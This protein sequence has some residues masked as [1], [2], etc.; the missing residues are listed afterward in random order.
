[1]MD[2][3]KLILHVLARHFMS[4]AKL[5]AEILVLRQ[6]V[7]VLRRQ[8]KRPHLNNADRLLF[9][10][11]YRCF[12]SLLGAIAIVRPATVIRWHRA[13]FRAL[14]VTPSRWQTEGLARA[15]QAPPTFTCGS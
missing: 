1:M 6:Q 3:F 4:R 2:L 11:F 5:Q 10:W 13:G 7:N 8:A 15:A 12:P 14:S 9:V